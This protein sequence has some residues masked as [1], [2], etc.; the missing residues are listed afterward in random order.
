[1]RIADAEDIPEIVR[2]INLA[3]QAEAFCLEGD[4]TDPQDVR[5][6]MDAGLFLVEPRAE[7]GIQ[8]TVY[9]RS[10]G[11][12]RWYLGLLSVDPALHGRGLGRLLVEAVEKYCRDQGGKF[13]DLTVVN[14]RR[15][16]FE[17]YPHLGFAPHGVMPFPRP[18]KLKFPCHLVKFTKAL[19]PA[20]EL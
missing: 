16:L 8:G 6:L 7:G 19:I 2:V 9:L 10:E 1:M 14:A 3:Y 17:F 18:V 5:T 15:E 12:A 4:R 20:W 13:L 11:E